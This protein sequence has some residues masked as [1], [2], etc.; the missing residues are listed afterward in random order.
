M[1]MMLE[2]LRK[3]AEF[4]GR[5]RRS[6]YWMF[7]LFRA[8]VYLGITFVGATLIGV[9]AAV[10]GGAPDGDISPLAS[11][12]TGLVVLLFLGAVLVFFIPSLAVLV[13]RLHDVSM[14]GW[15]VLISFIPFGG[16]VLFIFTL[17]DGTIGKNQYGPN[18]KEPSG[19]ANAAAVFE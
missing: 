18:P 13:R 8:L 19:A 5:A 1:D 2:A 4:E 15:L 3:Y 7:F 17:L 16:F 10:S 6:E 14:S 11:A 12:V 9:S